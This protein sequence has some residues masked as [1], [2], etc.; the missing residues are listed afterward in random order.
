MTVQIS[1]VTSRF[2]P[3]PSRA[4]RVKAAFRET[5]PPAPTWRQAVP[6]IAAVAAL[7]ALAFFA[8]HRVFQ[9]LALAADA[10]EEVADTIE[11]AAEDLGDAARARAGDSGD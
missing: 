10:I 6:A 5:A 11:D 9:A 7:A 3:T 1:A 8:R 4:A 2:R